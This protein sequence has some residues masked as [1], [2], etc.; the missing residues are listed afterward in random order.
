M[1]RA[2][3]A[4]TRMQIERA[5]DFNRG[6][7]FAYPLALALPVS[8]AAIWIRHLFDKNPPW[9]PSRSPSS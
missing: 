7:A 9:H 6:V 5:L 1:T 8:G 4:V 2:F 3:S